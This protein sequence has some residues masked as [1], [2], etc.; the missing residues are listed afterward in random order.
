MR[1]SSCGCD[2]SCKGTRPSMEDSRSSCSVRPRA[3][4]KEDTALSGP[5]YV[6]ATRLIHKMRGATQAHL[7]MA[8]DHHSYVVKFKNNPQHLR[9]LV[10]ELIASL[11]FR[12][13]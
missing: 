10:N 12:H 3:T 2:H 6:P 9:I 13:L 5:A 4:D 11:V 1:F 8:D 7:V